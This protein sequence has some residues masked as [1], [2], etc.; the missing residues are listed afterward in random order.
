MKSLIEPIN[1]TVLFH[2][3][4]LLLVMTVLFAEMRQMACKINFS[5]S[6]S[7]FPTKAI[8]FPD[9]ISNDKL[10]ITYFLSS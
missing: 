1:G 6:L 5:F 3:D 9:T 10:L 8:C 7:L 4:F 2:K